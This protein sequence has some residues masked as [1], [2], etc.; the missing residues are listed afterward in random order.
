MGRGA[1][2]WR[3]FSRTVR[4]LQ[5]MRHPYRQH[6]QTDNALA[7]VTFRRQPI[8]KRLL[9]DCSLAASGRR[10]FVPG[11]SMTGIR[12]PHGT[13]CRCAS[14]LTFK[15]YTTSGSVRYH[16]QLLRTCLIAVKPFERFVFP[17]RPVYADAGN[18]LRFN[19]DLPSPRLDLMNRRIAAGRW[20]R[21]KPTRKAMA[22]GR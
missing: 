22:C 7:T 14:A 20:T 11:S 16:A 9:S 1:V 19:Q 15:T 6:G 4:S 5:Q 21:P 10:R 13:D 17:N 18:R 2:P 3:I 8:T 12:Q